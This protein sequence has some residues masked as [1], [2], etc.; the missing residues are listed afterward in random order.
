LPEHHDPT[1]SEAAAPLMGQLADAGA[2]DAPGEDSVRV[3]AMTVPS[4]PADAAG[5]R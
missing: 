1:A 2:T 4:L 5:L 3:D